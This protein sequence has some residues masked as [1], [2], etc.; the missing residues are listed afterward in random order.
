MSI[1]LEL[2]KVDKSYAGKSALRGL[3]LRVEE[4]EYIS[5]L[6]PSGSGKS[7]L[8][9]IIAGFED[10]D[11]GDVLLAGRSMVGTLAH[12]RGIGFVFQNFALF[13]HMTVFDNVAF[14]LRH[15]LHNAVTEESEI[16]RRVEA[17]LD[18]VGLAGLGERAI[19]QI[20]G[21][22]KQRVALARTLVAD[23]KIILLDEP[24]G[25]LDANLRERMMVELRRIH[26]QLGITFVHV[27]GN[28][29]E[30]LAMG[31]RV[32][33]LNDGAVAQFAAPDT[34]YNRPASARVARFLNC[35]NIFSSRIVDGRF[36]YGE[37]A[38]ACPANTP[39]Q[40]DSARYCIRFDKITVAGAGSEPGPGSTRIHARFLASEYDGPTIT[41][42]FALPDGKALEVEHHLSHHRPE[43]FEADRIY[44]LL[45]PTEDVLI[46]TSD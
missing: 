10:P 9:R 37:A 21:G 18:M 38:L 16:R 14:G 8:L 23:P 22:Q 12:E 35:Y 44:S 39:Q 45:W 3:S 7:T 19:A 36:H 40:S 29:Q 6:G 33:V 2:A 25:A 5:L 43:E 26:R 20:S 30:A 34:V 42:F 41:Y 32:A 46:Y 28:E 11:A 13:P 31:D 4:G 17:I 24:L 27:T 15:R 1:I